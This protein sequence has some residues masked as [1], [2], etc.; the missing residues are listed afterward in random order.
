MKKI[1]SGI[2]SI[3][4][5]SKV[6]ADYIP[7]I[8]E[9]GKTVDNPCAIANIFNNFFVNVGKNT[10]KNIPCGNCCPTSFLKGNF[11]DSMFL[12]LV[13]S[14]EVDSYISQ[15]DNNKSIGPCSIPVPLLKILKTHITPFI[16]SLIDD[17]FR[18]GIFP[19][20][21]KLA[22]VTPVFKKGSRQDKANYRPISVLS[23]FSKIFEKAMFK[24]L[25]GYLESRNIL[26]P[27]QFGSRQKC[28]TNNALKQITESI[29]NSID[30]NEFGCGIFMD[31]KK[32]FEKVNHSIL[33][34]K[35]NHYGVRGKAC[36]WFQSYLSNREQFVC[37]NGHKSDSLS[38]A[39]G[40]PQGSIR[41][42]LMF[43]LYINDLHSRPQCL[44]VWE[45][46]RI[47]LLYMRGRALGRD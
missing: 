30:N 24:R 43:L 10:D 33:L 39:C 13:T 28:S 8:L 35:L 12:F 6:K 46:A 11:P 1:W 25:Y 42:P 19:R 41:G 18:C 26:Y 20:T 31:L 37:I 2:R 4:N 5:I 7:S 3:I 14:V 9:S 17:S 29:R 36:D 34:S 45:C 16:S 47:S 15:M 21:L 27:L 22:D 40:V 38:I 23:I 32:A 44:R